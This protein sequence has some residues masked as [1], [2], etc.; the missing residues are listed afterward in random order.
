MQTIDC[1]ASREDAADLMQRRE[2]RRLAVTDNGRV[3]GIRSHGNLVQASGN[4]GA[5]ATATLGV[6]KGA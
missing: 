5:T 3:V 4:D 1:E 2:V 6:T